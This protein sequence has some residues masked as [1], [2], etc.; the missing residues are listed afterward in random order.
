MS[1]RSTP[2][3]SEPVVT[4]RRGFVCDGV[5]YEAGEEI[6]KRLLGDGRRVQQL[7]SGRVIWD[8]PAPSGLVTR[9]RRSVAT[10]PDSTTE[11]P[12]ADPQ[13]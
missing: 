12:P 8:G 6:P 4:A 7:V 5:R 13:E 9:H 10:T 1:N 11:T 2:S 3:V